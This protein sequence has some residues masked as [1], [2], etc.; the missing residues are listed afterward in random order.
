MSR[1]SHEQVKWFLHVSAD[2]RLNPKDRAELETHLAECAS[3]RAYADE[4]H[5]L[6]KAIARALRS[7]WTPKRS[8]KDFAARVRSRILWDAERQFFLGFAR[9]GVKLGSL[10]MVAVLAVGMLQSVMAPSARVK[11]SANAAMASIQYLPQFEYSPENESSVLFTSPSAEKDGY[12]FRFVS[13]SRMV[14]TLY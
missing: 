9:T 13:P 10:V 11:S 7:R 8:R 2:K 6:N 12:P 3:C 1:L 4:L 14:V 5:W